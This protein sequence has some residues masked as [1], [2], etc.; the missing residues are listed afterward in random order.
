MT[1]VDQ[2]T[3]SRDVAVWDVVLATMVLPVIWY[4]YFYEALVETTKKCL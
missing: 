2:T 3:V 1:A 4:A